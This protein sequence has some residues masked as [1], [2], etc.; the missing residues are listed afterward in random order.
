MT[1]TPTHG[2]T[3]S[4]RVL[5]R[6]VKALEAYQEGKT[7]DEAATAAGYTNRG[8]AYRSV[9]RLLGKRADAAAA[10]LRAEANERHGAKIAM[11]EDIMFDLEQP[12][13]VRLRAAD[14][15][16]R[17]EARHARLNG[18]DAPVQVALSAGVSAALHDALADLE[19]VV[20][21]DVTAV[22]DEPIEEP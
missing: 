20:Q 1:T 11:L 22:T 21:G 2:D 10:T 19:Q 16:T 9:M 18:M 15:H 14:A 13:M 17:A 12:E 4:A 7:W 8:T 5:D 6:A 3:D